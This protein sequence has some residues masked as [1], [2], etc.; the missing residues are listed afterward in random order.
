MRSN[1]LWP[2]LMLSSL[3]LVAT[4]LVF[5]ASGTSAT[6]FARS[7]PVTG[8]LAASHA[9]TREGDVSNQT[10][11]STIVGD[12]RTTRVTVT[13]KGKTCHAEVSGPV[14]SVQTVT[15]NSRAYIEITGEDGHIRRIRCA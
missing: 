15:V 1:R 3:A 7:A 12:G 10:S 8:S 9:S 11:G 5:D 4:G 2:T 13:V 14:T 6:S